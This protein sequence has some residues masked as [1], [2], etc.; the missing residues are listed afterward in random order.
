M[1]SQDKESNDRVRA[2]KIAAAQNKIKEFIEA[3][4]DGTNEYMDKDM[5][6]YPIDAIID[7]YKHYIE[8]LKSETNN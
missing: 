2:L 4:E 5:K 7:F 6:L 1:D 8:E 3:K